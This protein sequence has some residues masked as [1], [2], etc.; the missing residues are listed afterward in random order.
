MMDK[1]MEV[2]RHAEYGCY[3][4]TVASR[5]EMNGMPLSIFTQVSFDPPLVLAGVSKKR[6]SSNSR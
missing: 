3:L 1:A 5:G 6:V 4:L 2:L